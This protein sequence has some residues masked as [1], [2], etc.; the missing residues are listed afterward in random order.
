M[1]FFALGTGADHP[2]AP[3]EP[4]LRPWA[5]IIKTDIKFSGIFSGLPPG[6]T[7]QKRNR[8]K[9]E[10]GDLRHIQPPAMSNY[11]KLSHS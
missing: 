8:I 1:K 3:A 10:P 2:G 5:V 6:P 4:S 7:V 9:T 11:E